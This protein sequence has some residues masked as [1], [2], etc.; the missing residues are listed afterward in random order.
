MLMDGTP[1]LS[2]RLFCSCCCA[3]G[4]NYVKL[5]A[6]EE[7]NVLETDSID[8]SVDVYTVEV[9][10]SGATGTLRAQC[11]QSH[12]PISQQGPKRVD[13]METDMLLL[14]PLDSRSRQSPSSPHRAA[15]GMRHRSSPQ[16]HNGCRGT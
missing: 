9:V 8:N 4:S 7:V 6:G 1:P 10:G 5:S 2:A 12:P 3:A 11:L 13:N 16:A 14:S 15:D